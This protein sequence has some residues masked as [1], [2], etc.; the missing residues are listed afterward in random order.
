MVILVILLTSLTAPVHAAEEP[1]L[2]SGTINH[3]RDGDTFEV[4]GISVRLTALRYPKDKT[5]LAE[6]TTKLVPIRAASYFQD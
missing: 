1:T 2:L 4:S 5:T 3:V 6:Q